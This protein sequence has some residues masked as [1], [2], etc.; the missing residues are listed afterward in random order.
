VV[1]LWQGTTNYG[2]T[3]RVVDEDEFL[4][5]IDD[6]H[7]PIP[8]SV[9]LNPDR[10]KEVLGWGGALQNIDWYKQHLIEMGLLN[11]GTDGNNPVLF[12]GKIKNETD[13]AILIDLADLIEP[14]WFA[15]STIVQRGKLTDRDQHGFEA[16]LWLLKKKVGEVK[17]KMFADSR[18]AIEK[19]LVT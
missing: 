6:Q 18:R 5:C 11:D 8:R 15:K 1:V 10:I 9:F 2:E 3:V 13:K 7:R 19:R 4:K 16:P 17:A 14:E 12:Y